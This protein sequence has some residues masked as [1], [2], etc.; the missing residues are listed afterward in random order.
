VCYRNGGQRKEGSVYIE[1]ARAA[2]ASGSWRGQ[3]VVTVQKQTGRVSI[4][5]EGERLRAE[6]GSQWSGSS[7]CAKPI[8]VVEC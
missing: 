3:F 1:V 5:S 2:R 7:C 8:G 6:K 4:T